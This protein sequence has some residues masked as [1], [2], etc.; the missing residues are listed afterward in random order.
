MCPRGTAFPTR[1]YVRPV[2]TQISLLRNLINVAKDPMRLQSD[3][4]FSL[5]SHIVL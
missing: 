3:S 5:G 2:E 1:L 4:D